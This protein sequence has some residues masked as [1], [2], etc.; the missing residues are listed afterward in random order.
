MTLLLAG[1]G[2]MVQGSSFPEK[3]CGCKKEVL[4]QTGLSLCPPLVTQCAHI[5]KKLGIVQQVCISLVL[6]SPSPSC[7]PHTTLAEIQNLQHWPHFSQIP[8]F[9]FHTGKHQQN[10]P[11]NFSGPLP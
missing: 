4:E 8:E 1:E 3:V 6:A 9:F 11:F 2:D 5:S 7:L 10:S